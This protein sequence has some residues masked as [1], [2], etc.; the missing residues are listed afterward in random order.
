MSPARAP[1][2]F[3]PHVALVLVVVI[4]EIHWL[5]WLWPFLVVSF[6]LP[7]WCRFVGAGW[8]VRRSF[9]L[10]PGVLLIGYLVAFVIAWMTATELPF[11]ALL[12]LGITFLLFGYSLAVY[13]W[14]MKEWAFAATVAGPPMVVFGYPVLGI[15]LLVGGTWYFVRTRRSGR[16]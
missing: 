12:V 10:G 2:F 5:N 13:H 1:W 11:F 3:V 16:S 14:K 4:G 9:V 7:W 15:A 6:A 8:S